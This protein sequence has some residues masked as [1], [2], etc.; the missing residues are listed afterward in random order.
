MSKNWGVLSIIFAMSLFF[1]N[2]AFAKMP[3]KFTKS[4]TPLQTQNGEWNK[5]IQYIAENGKF[6]SVEALG[7]IYIENTQRVPNSED[8]QSDYISLVGYV[9]SEGVFNA[10]H[11]EVVSEGWSIDSKNN[12]QIDQWLFKVDGYSNL[13]WGA[14]IDMIQTRDQQVLK[15]E[16]VSETQEMLNLQWQNQ[17]NSWYQFIN[18]AR[19][20]CT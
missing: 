13:K 17:L 16:Y 3:V 20:C 12:W 19:R 8:R 1:A 5:L 2:S 18:R 6:L 14:H 10:S 4:L 15:H 7:Y 11:L 9:D